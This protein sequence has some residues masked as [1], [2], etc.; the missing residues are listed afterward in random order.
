M[1]W[2]GRCQWAHVPALVTFVR[3]GSSISNDSGGCKLEL[4][5]TQMQTAAG[6]QHASNMPAQHKA[7]AQHGLTLQ[8][9]LLQYTAP[10]CRNQIMQTCCRTLSN[11]P[12]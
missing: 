4:I 7:V 10:L 3:T 1:C 5:V 2:T 11:K 8:S 6:R 12:H 9:K